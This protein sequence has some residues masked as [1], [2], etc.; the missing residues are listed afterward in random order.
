MRLEGSIEKDFLVQLVGSKLE[1]AAASEAAA[2]V[3][4]TAAAYKVAAKAAFKVWA[5][6]DGT[7]VVVMFEP[8]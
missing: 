2:V 1:V 7:S 5:A 3:E 4:S 6:A 8:T